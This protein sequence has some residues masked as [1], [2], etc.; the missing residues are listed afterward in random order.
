LSCLPAGRN[1]GL[2]QSLLDASVPPIVES[3]PLTEVPVFR[4]GSDER[5]AWEL[6]QRDPLQ[7][8]LRAFRALGPIYRLDMRGEMRVALAGLEANDFIWR[9]PKL[10]SYAAANTPFLEELGPDHVTALDGEHHREKRAILKSSFDQAPALRFLPQFNDRMAGE[11]A[12]AAGEPADLVVLWADLITK[13]NGQTVAQVVGN[14]DVA[15]EDA[16]RAAV[17]VGTVGTRREREVWA[18]L[19]A[20]R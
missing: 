5:A 10:W 12:A 14:Y 7:F 4:D 17:P 15:F 3:K 8:H 6:L 11:I 13:I 20:L 19:I 16:P 2:A 1:R 9:N 18:R